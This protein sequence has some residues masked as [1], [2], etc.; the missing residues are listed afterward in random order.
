M[1]V[2]TRFPFL[3]RRMDAALPGV[4]QAHKKTSFGATLYAVSAGS[5]VL[6]NAFAKL[7]PFAFCAKELCVLPIAH[8]DDHLDFDG[9]VVS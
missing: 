3:T 1:H 7:F 9:Q 2:H 8:S 5:L 4:I 6:A